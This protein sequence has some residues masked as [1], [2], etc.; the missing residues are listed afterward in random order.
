ML[1]Q[2]WMGILTNTRAIFFSSSFRLFLDSDKATISL[3]NMYTCHPVITEMNFPVKAICHDTVSGIMIVGTG[4]N[5]D[6]LGSSSTV[7]G[8]LFVY[9]LVADTSSYSRSEYMSSV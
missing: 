6:F 1:L 7:R 5:D 2:N 3:R 9:K 8:C 4:R